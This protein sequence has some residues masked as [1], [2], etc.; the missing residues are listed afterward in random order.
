[1]RA[2]CI[3][4]EVGVSSSIGGVHSELA[5]VGVQQLDVQGSDVSNV[6]V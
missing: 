1:M 3:G 2:E 5:E 6:V 4:D